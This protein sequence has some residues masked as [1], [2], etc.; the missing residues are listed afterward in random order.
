MNL[1]NAPTLSKCNAAVDRA[2]ADLRAF[3]P[4]PIIGTSDDEGALIKALQ[5]IEF[6]ELKRSVAIAK[7]GLRVFNYRAKGCITPN[8]KSIRR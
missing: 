4:S 3:H 8:G 2:Y 1:N 7:A 6:G 5:D